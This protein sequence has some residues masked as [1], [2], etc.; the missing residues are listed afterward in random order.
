MKVIIDLDK[1]TIVIE[2]DEKTWNREWS[3][4]PLSPWRIDFTPNTYPDGLQPRITYT[5]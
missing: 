2:D 1:K 5:T 4:I 3:T